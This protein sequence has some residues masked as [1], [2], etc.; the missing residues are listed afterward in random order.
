MLN[1]NGVFMERVTPVNK[2]ERTLLQ[3]LDEAERRYSNISKGI[4]K[5]EDN[6]AI[7]SEDLKGIRR[8]IEKARNDVTTG[9][10]DN[11]RV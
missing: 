2:R 7:V 9:N 4:K 6:L 11:L 8:D 10:L 1:D 5:L 3:R